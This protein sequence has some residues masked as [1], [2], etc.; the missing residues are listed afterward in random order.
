MNNCRMEKLLYSNLV[1]CKNNEFHHYTRYNLPCKATN[2]YYAAEESWLRNGIPCSEI[3][4][5]RGTAS[6]HIRRYEDES[7]VARQN[8]ELCRVKTTNAYHAEKE[9]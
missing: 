1:P 7:P 2:T 5:T 4:C 6:S 3:L 8:R 9:S